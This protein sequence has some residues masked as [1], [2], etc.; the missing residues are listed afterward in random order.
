MGAL[1]TSA[2]TRG[3]SRRAGRGG[4]VTAMLDP[5]LYALFVT[6]ALLLTLAPGPD[7]LFVLGASLGGGTRGGL[8][9]A[10]GILT[11]LVVHIGLAVVGVSMLIA[12]SPVAFDV[13]RVTGALYL[14]WI[15]VGVLRRAGRH[16]GADAAV[17]PTAR[18]WSRLYWQGTATNIL[19]PKVAVFY[20]A[21][22]PQFVAPELGHAPV[23]LFLLGLTHWLMGVPYL[24]TV[25][26]ASGA[27][28]AWLRRS[29][30]I[31]RGLDAVSGLVFIG[32]A[33]RLLAA[34]RTPA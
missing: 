11:G 6:A 27:V 28:A 23:Q 30:R 22:L 1:S 8:L 21:F 17:M 34:R 3:P 9:A 26:V 5:Q 10:A 7:T 2:G 33:L 15:G 19:N 14:V 18:T 20:V 24:V 12:T 31:R 29:P 13:L 4:R 16:G 25:A 32:L